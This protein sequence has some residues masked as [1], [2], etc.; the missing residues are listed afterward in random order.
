VTG[1]E[2]SDLTALDLKMARELLRASQ[3]LSQSSLNLLTAVAA[4]QTRNLPLQP[5]RD[6]F[7]AVENLMPSVEEGQQHG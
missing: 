7:N 4:N 5:L 1:P 2:Q 6:A 3:Q